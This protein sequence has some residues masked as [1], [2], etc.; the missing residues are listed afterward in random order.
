MKLLVIGGSKESA[1]TLALVLKVRW[2][3]LHTTHC[4]QPACAVAEME[5]KPPDLVIPCVDTPAQDWF[6]LVGQVRAC[7]DIP[8]IVLSRSEDVLSKVQALEMGADDWVTPSC[9]PMEFV[10]KVNAVLRRCRWADSPYGVSSHGNGKFC[11]DHSNRSVRVNGSCVKL[12]PTEYKVLC[13][14]V[15]RPG[16]VVSRDELLEGVWGSSPTDPEFL[17]KYI[18]RLRCKLEQD[19]ARPT[20][21]LNERGVGYVFVPPGD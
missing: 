13:K 1:S 17:K 5:K 16:T 20:V 14:L 3:D 11:I 18:R 10:A 15:R 21:I 8:I 19:P 6:D 2:A 12:T 4:I 9:L 7:S